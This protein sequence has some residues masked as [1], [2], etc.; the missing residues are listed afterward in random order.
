VPRYTHIVVSAPESSSI[1]AAQRQRKT[2][3]GVRVEAHC[4]NAPEAELMLLL[5]L[6]GDCSLV[7]G[8][9]ELATPIEY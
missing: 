8:V 6:D 4:R 2:I 3:P 5:A 9:I 7:L 1:T